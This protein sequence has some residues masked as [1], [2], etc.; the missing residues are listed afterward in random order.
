[1]KDLFL[2]VVS[3]RG[4]VHINAG[5]CR[6]QKGV[7]DLLGLEVEAVVSHPMWMLG[8]ELRPST[9]SVN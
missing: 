3:V 2:D 6:A 9:S 1:M 7:P 5:A 8:R 4:Y